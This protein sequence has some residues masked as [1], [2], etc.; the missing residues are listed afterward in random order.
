MGP[1]GLGVR[2]CHRL[3]GFYYSCGKH[4]ASQISAVSQLE[5]F[6]LERFVSAPLIR[7]FISEISELAGTRFGQH[8]TDPVSSEILVYL[9]RENST[10]K[11]QISIASYKALY[12]TTENLPLLMS[13]LANYFT[14]VENTTSK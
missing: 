1:G 4:Q 5:A 9:L 13:F 7:P 2:F 8:K 6:P 3:Q 12:L 10:L 11:F 14:D